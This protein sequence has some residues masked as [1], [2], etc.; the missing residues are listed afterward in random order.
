MIIFK[1][2]SSLV[3]TNTNIVQQ[4]D[5][6]PTVLEMINYDQNYFSFGK[7]MLKNQNWTINYLEGKY[8][9][10]TKKGIVINQNEEYENYMDL[11]LKNK[12][13]NTEGENLMKA[14]KQTYSSKIIKNELKYED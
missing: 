12:V 8:R 2:D 5:I 3:G 14:I 6:M 11:N 13:D 10:L 4:I 7:S 1:G 9:L